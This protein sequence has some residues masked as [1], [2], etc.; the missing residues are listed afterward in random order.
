MT[1]A[2]HSEP[3]VVDLLALRRACAPL[4]RQF[5]RFHA[6][7]SLDLDELDAALVAIRRLPP[8]GGRLG[9]ALGVLAAGAARSPHETVAAFELVRNT[10]ALRAIVRRPSPSSSSKPARQP[11]VA[12]PR[13]PGIG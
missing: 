8:V 3:Q 13:L 5:D 6:N 9:R 11:R 1:A 7:G 10:P 2:T 4:V 12:A